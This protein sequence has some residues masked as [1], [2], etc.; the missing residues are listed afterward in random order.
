MCK[1]CGVCKNPLYRQVGRLVMVLFPLAGCV[2][3][4]QGSLYDQS[5][6]WNKGA[7]NDYNDLLPV[8][9]QSDDNCQHYLFF[10]PPSESAA[11]RIEHCRN[12]DKRTGES[13][14]RGLLKQW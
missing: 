2:L 6:L 5:P 3:W 4:D 8:A 13:W 9:A 10:S 12:E 14:F 7:A 1:F 11:I